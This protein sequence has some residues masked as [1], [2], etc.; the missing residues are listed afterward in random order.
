MEDDD[1]TSEKDHDCSGAKYAES[2]LAS[3][4]VEPSPM[5]ERSHPGALENKCQRYQNGSHDNLAHKCHPQA[6]NPNVR[7]AIILFFA[8]P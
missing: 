3:F 5:N 7:I 6:S 8:A 1:L 2:V 4:E